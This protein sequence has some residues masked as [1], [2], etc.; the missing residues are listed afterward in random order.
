M[1][2]LHIPFAQSVCFWNDLLMMMLER[3]RSLPVFMRTKFFRIRFR[4]SIDDDDYSWKDGK[5]FH[6]TTELKNCP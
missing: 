3:C 1:D 4:K 6:T 5:K 2:S